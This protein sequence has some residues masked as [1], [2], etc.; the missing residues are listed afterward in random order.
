MEDKSVFEK[1]DDIQSSIDN[2]TEKKTI[3]EM[4]GEP[5]DAYFESSEVYYYEPNERKFNKWKK[6]KLKKY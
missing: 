4:I 2:Q 5:F 6:E 1:L 3:S